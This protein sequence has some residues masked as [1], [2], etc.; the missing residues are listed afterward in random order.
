MMWEIISSVWHNKVRTLLILVLNSLTFFLALSTLTNNFAFYTQLS[1]IKNMFRYDPK[2]IYRVDA[3]KIENED[4]LGTDFEELKAFVNAQE[5]AVCGAYDVVGSYFDE[6]TDDPQFVA[7]NKKAYIGKKYEK[8]PSIVAVVYIDVEILEIVDFKL[9]ADDFDPVV[10]N[11][12]LYTPLYAGKDFEGVLSLGDILT[13][14]GVGEKYIVAGFLDNEKWFDN[15]D[16]ITMPRVS[17]NHMFFAPFSEMEKGLSLYSLNTVHS[18]TVGKIFMNCDKSIAV[19]FNMRAAEKGIKFNV[20]SIY[21]FTETWKA[22]KQYILNNNLFLTV[23]VLVC[24]MIS[25]VSTLCVSIL[26]KKKEYGIKIAFG[27]TKGKIIFSLC[28]EM[29][30]LNLVSGIIAF[31]FCYRSFAENII[32]SYHRDIYL[33][34]LCSTSL[35]C[36]IGLVIVLMVLVLFIPVKLLKQYDPAVLIKEEE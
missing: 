18:S 9:T 8:F 13:L 7:L 27:C 30:F 26:L 3:V 31:I 23:I 16:S 1:D 17:L 25:I 24:S 14:S 11:E 2:N 21:D 19:E 6:L 29:L 36:L 28:G 33:R 4:N 20:P 10:I 12:E 5:N 35:L 22:S 34:T 15:S 32:G